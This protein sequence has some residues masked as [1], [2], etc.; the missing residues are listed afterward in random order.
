MSWNLKI[1]SKIKDFVW[2]TLHKVLPTNMKLA[3]KGI[4][5]TPQCIRCG[6]PEDIE[7]V[8]FQCEFARGCWE[9]WESGSLITNQPFHDTLM[10]VGS[11]SHVTCTEEFCCI[12]WG[13]WAARNT[14]TWKD[15]NQ[16]PQ[17]VYQHSIR[18]LRSWKEAMTLKDLVR[19]V[20]QG[21]ITLQASESTL[22]AEWIFLWASSKLID[23]S[24]QHSRKLKRQ[25]SAFGEIS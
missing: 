12:S 23:T 7:H 15:E 17:Q 6:D 5:L 25:V 18:V 9:L 3:E 1:P 21:S 22:G 2:R 8:I 16:S 4:P 14:M 10:D 11:R 20:G 19:P 24:N 13:I